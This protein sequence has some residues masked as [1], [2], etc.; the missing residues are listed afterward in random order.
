MS[1]RCF[2]VGPDVSREEFEQGASNAGFYHFRTQ[3]GDRRVAY[4]QVWA[5]EGRATAINYLEDPLLGLKWISF[6]GQDLDRLVPSLAEHIALIDGEG[7]LNMAREATEPDEMIHAIACLA[8]TFPTYDENAYRAFSHFATQIPDARVRE[9][10][11]NCTAYRGWPAFVPLLKWVV[12]HD[13]SESV[14]QRAQD[15]LPFLDDTLA[16]YTI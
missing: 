15:I 11:I 8:A 1:S 16:S 12:E 6:R 10:A 2:V 14:R 9:S 3:E 13:P 4:E 7:A 5:T